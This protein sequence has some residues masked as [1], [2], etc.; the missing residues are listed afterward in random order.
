MGYTISCFTWSFWDTQKSTKP[1]LALKLSVSAIITPGG[2][3]QSYFWVIFLLFGKCPTFDRKFLL[4]L[5]LRHLCDLQYPHTNG[6][7]LCI[8]FKHEIEKSKSEGWGQVHGW[9][10]CSLLI[11][12]LA[13]QSW[14][15]KRPWSHEI[16]WNL[17]PPDHIRSREACN[18][19]E[20]IR[21]EQHI[22]LLLIPSWVDNPS[23]VKAT[24]TEVKLFRGFS[25]F[26]TTGENY[27]FSHGWPCRAISSSITKEMAK[28]FVK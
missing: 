18:S 27:H 12:V 7:L 1:I 19:W 24:N 8:D 3:P 23:D 17:R 26:F 2:L 28:I 14:A 16:S 20:P 25:R 4:F 22:Y 5:L 10:I 21:I 15:L 9:P 13:W 6:V 11:S